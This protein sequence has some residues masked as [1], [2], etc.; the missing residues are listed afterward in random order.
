MKKTL[1]ELLIKLM[2]SYL[3]YFNKFYLKEITFNEIRTVNSRNIYTE[4]ETFY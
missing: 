3:D 2:H 4:Q 1:E